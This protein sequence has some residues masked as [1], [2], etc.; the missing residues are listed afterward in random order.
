MSLLVY[1]QISES[2]ES[3]KKIK[4]W[5]KCSYF[6]ISCL[7]DNHL[8]TIIFLAIQT[9]STYYKVLH[10]TRTLQKKKNMKNKICAPLNLLYLPD[11]FSRV[12]VL[13]AIFCVCVCVCVYVL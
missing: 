9:E 7:K 10:M 13:I 5:N 8:I 11:T 12:Q 6:V 1:V 2:F 4:Q 3:K